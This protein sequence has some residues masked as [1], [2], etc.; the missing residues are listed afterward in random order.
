M[1]SSPHLPPSLLSRIQCLYKILL[2]TLVPSHFIHTCILF[3]SMLWE[4]LNADTCTVH[5][6]ALK[7]ASVINT[8][9]KRGILKTRNPLKYD[10][11]CF[12][13]MD[14]SFL[15]T[16]SRCQVLYR[17]DLRYNKHLLDFYMG[18]SEGPGWKQF[19]E[20]SSVHSFVERSR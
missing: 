13:D 17:N 5:V 3:I 8:R 12:V 16:H 14:K 1:Q 19:L 2:K 18:C 4:L 9:I 7:L 10:R 11:N 20:A 6:F 15:F